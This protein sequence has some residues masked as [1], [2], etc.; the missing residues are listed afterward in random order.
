MKDSS[1]YDISRTEYEKYP[2]YILLR[3]SEGTYAYSERKNIPES[4]RSTKSKDHY[5]HG[6]ENVR[7]HTNNLGQWT[8]YF[9]G[10]GKKN[11][12]NTENIFY[13]MIV[14]S[15]EANKFV[16]VMQAE[17]PPGIS[18]DKIAFEG[19]CEKPETKPKILPNWYYEDETC[20]GYLDYMLEFAINDEYFEWVKIHNK[21]E[22]KFL[23]YLVTE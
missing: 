5:M 14:Y 8:I 3:K 21:L 15:S 6:F 10:Y 13:K 17:V 18:K 4:M 16:T 12:I 22:K 20:K 11:G 23:N 19:I 7:S 2:K 9:K 1:L